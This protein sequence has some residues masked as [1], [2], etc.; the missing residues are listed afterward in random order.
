MR[1]TSYAEPAPDNSETKRNVW[2]RVENDDEYDVEVDQSED[3]DEWEVKKIESVI[4]DIPIKRR[5]N[6]MKNEMRTLALETV[7]QL[8]SINNE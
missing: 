3:N 8:N 5:D 2:V 4:A 6:D 1:V 7:N